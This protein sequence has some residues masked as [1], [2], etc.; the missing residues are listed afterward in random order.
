MTLDELDHK[1][2]AILQ[3]NARLPNADVAVQ[4]G[5]SE[6]TVRKARGSP[7]AAWRH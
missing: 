3:E 6:A 4:V 1:I 2:I 5:S 7:P